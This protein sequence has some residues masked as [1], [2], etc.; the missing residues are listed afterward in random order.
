MLLQESRQGAFQLSGAVPVDE[1]HDVQ[2]GQQRLVEEPLGPGQRFI[3]AAADHVQIGRRRR[4][5]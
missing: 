4:L 5:A 3:H 1:A 2:I